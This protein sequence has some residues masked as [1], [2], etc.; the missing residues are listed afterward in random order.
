VIDINEHIGAVERRVGTRTLPAGQVR[1]VTITRTFDAPVDEVWAA[2]TDP[3]RIPRWFL[4]VTGELRPGGRY[5]LEG[6][7][8]GVIERCDPPR[9]FVATWEYGGDVSGIEVRLRPGP[10]GGT[11][12][13]LDH[14]GHVDDAFW[15]EFGPGAVGVGWE[16][17][18]L[19]LAGHLGAAGVPT[20]DRS[21]AWSASAEGRTFV[22]RSSEEWGAAHAASGADPAAAHAAAAR[23]A[24]AYTAP[25]ETS[26]ETADD[27]AHPAADGSPDC[28]R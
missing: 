21:A 12:Q 23:T 9:S 22:M 20:P 14:V 16:L 10:G 28:A 26:G 1:V 4:P 15:D 7:A 11:L 17:G 19:G 2:C 5:Q 27:A 18:L 6:N 3:T 25:G 8:G 24:A 13:T